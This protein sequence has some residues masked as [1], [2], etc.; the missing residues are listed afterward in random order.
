MHGIITTDWSHFPNAPRCG[1]A[2]HLRIGKVQK[3][4]HS[5]KYTRANMQ[6]AC[7]VTGEL[8]VV[9][10]ALLAL[11]CG[12]DK[13]TVRTDQREIR[14]HIAK[15]TPLQ[16]FQGLPIHWKYIPK[17][18]RDDVFDWCHVT[19]TYAADNTRSIVSPLPVP[20]GMKQ[21]ATLW[22]DQSNLTGRKPC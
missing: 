21:L 12:V 15:Y 19:S 6:R 11:P 1:G 3:I 8:F 4:Q 5:I 16:V 9:L 2:Y 20:V 13:I 22:W 18:D 7:S 17:R 14:R 10:H